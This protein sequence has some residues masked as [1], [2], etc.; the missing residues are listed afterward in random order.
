[1][2]RGHEMVQVLGFKEPVFYKIICQCRAIL[3]YSKDDMQSREYIDYGGD[4][5]VAYS[6]V[7]PHCS[8]RLKVQG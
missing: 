5:Q 2:S 1:M 3:Q 4:K 6:I 8:E 7:C